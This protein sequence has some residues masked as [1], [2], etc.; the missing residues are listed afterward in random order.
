MSM[1]VRRLSASFRHAR[2]AGVYCDILSLW[3]GKACGQGLGGIYEG[4]LAFRCCCVLCTGCRMVCDVM[5][6]SHE[7]ITH[8]S[9]LLFRVKIIMTMR[10]CLPGDYVCYPRP[11]LLFD[12]LL[13]VLFAFRTWRTRCYDS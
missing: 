12:L 4:G 5:L 9:P 13:T 11:S 2:M 3:A 6:P 7:S 10:A 1:F 8:N